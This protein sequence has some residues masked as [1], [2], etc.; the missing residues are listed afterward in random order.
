LLELASKSGKSAC[1]L[2]EESETQGMLQVIME[3][4]EFVGKDKKSEEEKVVVEDVSE[5]RTSPREK[6]QSVLP[7]DFIDPE[8][9][10]NLSV[11][12][13]WCLCVFGFKFSLRENG[14]ADSY[15]GYGL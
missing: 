8:Q 6:I 11:L 5:I 1:A 9:V 4:K 2:A 7:E 10:G 13:L 14:F 15:R 3:E 12:N